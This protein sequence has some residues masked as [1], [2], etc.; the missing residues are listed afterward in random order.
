M[1]K[2]N[3]NQFSMP[4]YS[5]KPIN[6]RGKLDT[7]LKCNY[8]CFFCYYR[9]NLDDP[10]LPLE[11]IK[12]RADILKESGILEVDLSGGEPTIHSKWFEI[13][14]YC[15]DNFDRV[16][17]LSNGAKLKDFKFAEKSFKYGLK[18]VLFSLHGHNEKIHDSMVGYSGAF[19]DII[20]AID[21][22]K[23]IGI[24]VRINCTVTSKNMKYLDEYSELIKKIKPTQLNYLPLNYWDDAEV[25]K[26]E[27]YEVL[28]SFI[29]NS[30]NILKDE[31]IEI[32]V[33]YI[34]YCFM[35]GYEKYVCDT[36]Q[37]IHDLKDW[38]IFTYDLKEPKSFTIIDMY[39]EAFKKRN[40]TY[41]KTKKCFKCRFFYICDGIEKKLEN[42]DVYPELGEKIRDPMEFR[43]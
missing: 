33:R 8:N 19:K 18:E 16:S 30:I 26:P 28:S 10:E 37:H 39:K 43:G 29:K 32:N 17:C 15:V 7:G 9:K 41:Y 25:M 3:Y 20:Q 36:F 2:L 1:K 14:E 31:D 23:K 12:K 27:K 11:E 6:R 21:N 24:E 40:Y 22:C 35:V 5:N 42:Q 13:L 4:T 38:N 34:P